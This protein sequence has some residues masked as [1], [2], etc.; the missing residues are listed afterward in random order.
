MAT[1]HINA[2]ESD[3]ASI[4]IM[5]GDPLRAKY[6]AEKY[7]EEYH[8]VSDVRMNLGYTGYYKNTKV[9]IFSSGMGMPS[10][11]I[12][13]YELFKNYNVKKIIRLGSCGS[14]FKEI[15]VR[16]LILVE[17]AY[18]TSNFAYQYS[19][20]PLQICR[21]NPFL[22]QKIIKQAHDQGIELKIGNINTS[23][24]FYNDYEDENIKANY[25]LGVEMESFALFYIANK[26]DREATSL[27]TVSDN[28]VTNEKMTSLER[29]QTLDQAITLALDSITL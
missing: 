19:G 26:L 2:N 16:D 7:L 17:K 23:D 13:A 6:I 25:C 21:S 27:L 4:V 28:L 8:L 12:Y 24:I 14:Y 5:P 1:P 3:I 29:E 9:T 10:M 18:T 11:G 15:K 20:V 22:N